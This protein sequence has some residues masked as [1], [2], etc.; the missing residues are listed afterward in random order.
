[1]RGGQDFPSGVLSPDFQNSGFAPEPS[2]GVWDS[3]LS[4]W[5][6][7]PFRT[8]GQILGCLLKIDTSRGKTLSITPTNVY[9]TLNQPW[10]RDVKGEEG[11]RD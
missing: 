1:M 7:P 10:D 5:T 9:I 2:L 4:P 8:W 6:V 11:H 3:A